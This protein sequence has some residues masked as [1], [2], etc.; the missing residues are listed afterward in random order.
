MGERYDVSRRM[1]Y[2]QSAGKAAVTVPNYL[3]ASFASLVVRRPTAL[4]SY[5][6]GPYQGDGP[7]TLE[8]FADNAAPLSPLVDV[9]CNDT[10]SNTFI[11][12]YRYEPDP[13]SSYG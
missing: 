8:M 12:E 11:R 4:D 10:T 3:L 6:T 5:Y 7:F 2:L 9:D 1:L 13:T